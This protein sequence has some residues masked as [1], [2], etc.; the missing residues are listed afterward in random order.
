MTRTKKIG[1][2]KKMKR[3]NGKIRTLSELMDLQIAFQ[4]VVLNMQGESLIT[5]PVDS[6]KWFSY[7]MNAMTEEMGEVL[8]ADKRWKTHR[9]EKYDRCEKLDEIADVFITAMNIAI[10]SNYTAEELEE[11]IAGKVK[12]NLKRIRGA[13]GS[14]NS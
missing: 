10:F 1:A 9:N 2:K 8:K 6:T 13:Y 7:H 3:T 4:R 5:L 12:Q 11:A 14:N